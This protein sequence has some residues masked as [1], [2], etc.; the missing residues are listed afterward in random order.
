MDF[1]GKE[2]VIGVILGVILS[3]VASLAGLQFEGVKAGICGGVS[4]L[5]TQS[6]TPAE[7][8]K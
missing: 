6:P 2:K 7:V 8:K 5:E 4:S 3:I 1:K